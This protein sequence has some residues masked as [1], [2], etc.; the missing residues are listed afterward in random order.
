MVRGYLA[1]RDDPP[2]FDSFWLEYRRHAFSGFIMAI[3]AS[4]H[5]EQTERGDRMFAAMA[6]RPVQMA[7][8]LDS[9]SLI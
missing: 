8:D 3:N 9:L 5:V 2:E 7:I 1:Q 4:L 6:K